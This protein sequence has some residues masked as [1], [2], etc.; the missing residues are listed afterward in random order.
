MSDIRGQFGSVHVIDRA[1][2]VCV[3]ASNN[4]LYNTSVGC[5]YN[6]GILNIKLVT[7]SSSKGQW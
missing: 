1:V 4:E 2:S 7:R 6:H 3:W 5:P